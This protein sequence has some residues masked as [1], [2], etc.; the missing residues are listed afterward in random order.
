MQDWIDQGN[1]PGPVLELEGKD[2]RVL[3]ASDPQTLD[4]LAAAAA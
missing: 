1:G 2:V 3:F 4:A